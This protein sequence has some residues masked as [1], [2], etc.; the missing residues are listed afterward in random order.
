MFPIPVVSRELIRPVDE[1]VLPG[2]RTWPGSGR[3]G[4]GGGGGARGG[5]GAS[6]L[7]ADAE[8]RVCPST[9]GAASRTAVKINRTKT[10]MTGLLSV[11]M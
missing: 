3:R 7:P 4:T 6:W 11:F 10:F 5:D 9:A 2:T 1:V 8:G